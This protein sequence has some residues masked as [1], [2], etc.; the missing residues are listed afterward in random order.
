MT[1]EFGDHAKQQSRR[2]T[3]DRALAARLIVLVDERIGVDA[4]LS[5]PADGIVGIAFLDVDG[6]R[7]AVLGETNGELV[8]R[9]QNP[10]VAALSGKKHQRPQ[11]YDAPLVL[12]GALLDGADLLGKTEALPR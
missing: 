5:L 4:E 3:Q 9:I 7:F 12:G 11:R 8:C 6:E 10:G 1:L 2:V